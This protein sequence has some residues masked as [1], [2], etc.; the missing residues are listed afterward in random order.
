MMDKQPMDKQLWHR[1]PVVG[2]GVG[3]LQSAVARE[4][5]R[6]IREANGDRLKAT[7]IVLDKLVEMGLITESELPVLAGICE[8]GFAATSGKKDA[9][10]AYHEVRKAYDEMLLKPGAS[11]VALAFASASAGSYVATDGGEDGGGGT[12]V[13]YKK[14]GGN[15][16]E[17]LAGAGAAI[18]GILGG[19]A[20]A[21]LGTVIGGVAGKIVDE[22]LD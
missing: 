8:E 7:K 5:G 6:I 9:A 3:D 4:T 11:P 22:C 17:T 2:V 15:W 13:V 18:G 16:Q 20:G 12:T 1:G 19:A 14:S 10:A 21:G